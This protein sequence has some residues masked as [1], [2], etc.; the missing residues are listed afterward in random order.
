MRE[1]IVSKRIEALATAVGHA[2]SVCDIGC[3]HGYLSIYMVRKHI[4]DKAYAMDLRVGP[5]SKARD[6]IH[7]YGLDDKIRTVLSDGFEA[8]E[9]RMGDT[10][11]I[12]G[13]GGEL[14]IDILAN[15]LAK[16]NLNG[17]S[18]I[19]LSPHTNVP[20]VREYVLS[21]GFVI[22]EEWLMYDEPKYYSIMRLKKGDPKDDKP[23]SRIELEYGRRL[24]EKKDPIL[25]ERTNKDIV[26]LKKV[27]ESL[28][29]LHN[30]DI[31]K[32]IEQLQQQIREKEDVRNLL[33]Q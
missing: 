5:L 29:E 16:G 11:V 31:Q 14:I 15:A 2:E 18:N 20:M 7:E 9:P 4:C 33:C 3:D 25:L 8:Y 24:L 12:A 26:K 17:I 32:R 22:D 1:L 19:I 23:Y 6:N 10:A 27:A 28:K 30:T 13:M 21:H